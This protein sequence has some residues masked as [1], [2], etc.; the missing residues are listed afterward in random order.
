MSDEDVK[1][2]DIPLPPISGLLSS[3]SALIGLQVLSRAVTFILNQFL[4]R[5]A[6]P[7]A[8][9]TAAI[10]FEL[11]LG[12]IL[13]LAR[14][15]VRGALIRGWPNKG[16]DGDDSVEQRAKH[17][18]EGQPEPTNAGHV[19]Q[20]VKNVAYV[21]LM[22]GVPLALGTSLL[23]ARMAAVETNAQPG[24][25]LAIALYAVAAVF[26]LMSEPMHIRAMGE[27]RT[28]VRVRAEGWGVVVK[29]LTT[30]AVM[31]YDAKELALVAFALGQLAYAVTV[32]AIYGRAFGGVRVWPIRVASRA[33]GQGNTKLLHTFFDKGTVEL[34]ATMTAQSLVKHFLTEGDKVIL[35][36]LSPLEDQGGY[37]IAVN[38]GSL[39]ARIVLQPLEEMARI[40]FSNLLPE[41]KEADAAMQRKEDLSEENKSNLRF[42]VMQASTTLIVFLSLQAV[43]SILLLTFGTVYLPFALRLLLPPRYLDT[44]AP[45]VLAAWIWYIP[46]LAANGTLEA[47]LASVASP[48]DLNRQSR[49]MIAFSAI[50]ISTALALYAAGFGDTSLVYANI[51]NL[52]AR[53][54][55]AAHFTTS[56]FRARGA[57]NLL[58]WGDVIPQRPLLAA[59]ALAYGIAKAADWMLGASTALESKGRGALFQRPVVMQVSL[60]AALGLACLVVWWKTAIHVWLPRSRKIE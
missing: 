25:R 52:S 41:L 58:T 21:P 47:F 38:Y 45:R 54:A 6:D 53:I 50:Y 35:S 51:V 12:T 13:F 43:F 26:E 23:Y 18:I 17:I 2:S 7:R 55:Y 27:L 24:F 22:L 36:S 40:Y 8:F 37:A 57:R 39:V 56:Y 34:S 42:G 19:Q 20:T 29:T 46:V 31:F 10:Q 49:W 16:H 28:E 15:G 44:S 14:E 60:G 33:R 3:A 32:L 59:C 9:G 4:L 5:L 48:A 11:L 30:F 1:P